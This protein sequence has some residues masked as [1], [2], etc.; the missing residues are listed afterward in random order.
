MLMTPITRKTAGLLGKDRL[1]FMR[2]LIG[3]ALVALGVVIG[4]AIRHYYNIPLAETINIV[5]MATLATTIFLA[6]YIPTVLDRQLQIKQD[7]KHVL[8]DR[9]E[10]IQGIYRRINLF[11]QQGP[12][13][14]RDYMA[15]INDVDIVI[16]RFDTITTLLQYFD[17]K[18]SFDADITQIRSLEKQYRELLLSFKPEDKAS[19]YPDAIKKQEEPL[20]NEIDKATSLLVFKISDR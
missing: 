20:Y 9:L 10:E 1:R 6:L 7:K 11:V 5:D 13:S 16:H 12:V 17:Q 4:I 2:Y 15:V 14:G 3:V 8:I 19:P 18:V